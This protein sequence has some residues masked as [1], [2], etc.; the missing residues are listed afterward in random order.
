DGAYRKGKL[1]DLKNIVDR[2]A[3]LSTGIDNVIVV[4]NA[5]NK[6]S[7]VSDRDYYYD[8]ILEDSYVEPERMDSNDP[9]FILYTSGTTGKPKGIVH[10]NGGYPV[11]VANTLKWAFD[12]KEEDRYWCT[13]DFGWITGHSFAVFGPLIL[14]LTSIIYEGAIDYPKPDR[15]WEIIE[16]YGVNILYTS[17]TAIR[18]LMK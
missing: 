8:E 1:I 18:L 16:R 17:P 5:N 4:R 11:W 3:D 6:I 15:M 9:L 12:P 7:M 2:A 13:A 10:G 14:G